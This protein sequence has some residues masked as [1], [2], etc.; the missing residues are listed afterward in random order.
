MTALRKNHSPIKEI[1][2][3]VSIDSE[4]GGLSLLTPEGEKFEISK[5]DK[6]QMLGNL[7]WETVKVIGRIA[8]KPKRQILQVNYFEPINTSLTA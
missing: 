7:L 5:S 8:R 4:T 1:Y 2:G 6:G 3:V